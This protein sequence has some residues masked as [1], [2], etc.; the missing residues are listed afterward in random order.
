LIDEAEEPLAKV[1]AAAER[2]GNSQLLALALGAKALG[3][4]FSA[5]YDAAYEMG[6]R[7]LA[8][9]R[10]DDVWGRAD[11]QIKLAQACWQLGKLDEIEELRRS[12][13]PL[14]RRALHFGALWNHEGLGCT[15]ALA[16]TG[17]FAA[18]L[19]I[20]EGAAR[21]PRFTF[22]V[23]CHVALAQLYS[24]DAE[25]ALAEIAAVVAAQPAEHW[26]MGLVDGCAFL[27]NALAGRDD[28]ARALAPAVERRLPQTGR[29]N[30]QGMFAALATYVLGNALLGDR[31]RCAAVYPLT[32]LEIAT[33]AQS[34]LT[35]L[36]ASHPQLSAALAAEAAG[37]FEKAC[38]HFDAAIAH[39]N[40]IPLRPV[41][42]IALFFYG[43]CLAQRESPA[44]RER[45]R[46]MLVAALDD[47][48]ALKMTLF[49]RHAEQ[50]LARAS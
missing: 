14:A 21:G 46:A 31:D 37:L 4:T 43:R 39:A 9:Y 17:D 38:E 30:T 8:T 23:K 10:E 16:R 50:A 3:H 47:F 20:A 27:A 34:T 2:T 12:G 26:M 49:A 40:R 19:A 24:G 6:R 36:P 32:L 1:L 45:G 28:E 18:Y 48:R 11:E 29:R 5:E 33:G 15:T 7:A 35:T 25:R 42:P 13:E 41:Q 44:D 22:I